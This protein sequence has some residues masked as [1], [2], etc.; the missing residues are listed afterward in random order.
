MRYA[1]R[2]PNPVPPL[3][4]QGL[5]SVLMVRSGQQLILHALDQCFHDQVGGDPTDSFFVL[6]KTFA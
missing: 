1:S 3:V 6:T 2:E 4:S 5:F